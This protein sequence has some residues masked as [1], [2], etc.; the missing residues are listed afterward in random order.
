[1]AHKYNNMTI[2]KSTKTEIKLWL[3]HLVDLMIIVAPAYIGYEI[4]SRSP[5]PMPHFITLM[6]L[7]LCFSLF[8]CTKNKSNAYTRNFVIIW[9]LIKMDRKTYVRDGY[10]GRCG[11]RES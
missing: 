4:N 10:D 2:L 8:L 1:M 9:K 6:V 3:F 5:L 7:W 11:E